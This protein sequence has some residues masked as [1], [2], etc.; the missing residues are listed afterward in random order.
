MTRQGCHEEVPPVR[1]LRLVAGIL[2][3]ASTWETSAFRT[4]SGKLVTPGMSMIEVLRDAGEPVR[5]T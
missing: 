5:C 1:G 4:S 2:A 3:L